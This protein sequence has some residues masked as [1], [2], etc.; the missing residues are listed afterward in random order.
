MKNFLSK[1]AFWVLQILGWGCLGIFVILANDIT[2]SNAARIIT[3]VGF[4]FVSIGVTSITR[5]FFRR[6]ID[7]QDFKAIEFFKIV[8]IIVGTTLVFP[9]VSYWFGYLIGKLMKFLFDDATDLFRK[10]EGEYDWRD[11]KQYIGYLIIVTGWTVFYFV[12]KVLRQV[13][14]QRVNRLELKKK[15]RQAQLNTLKGHINPQFMFNTLNNIKGLMLEDVPLSRAMLT[16]LS[17]MLRYS[18]TKNS[19]NTVLIAEE[20]EMVE[21]YVALTQIQHQDRFQIKYDIPKETLRLEIPP[22]LMHNL[23]EHAAKNGI[24]LRRTGGEIL[25]QIVRD[26]NCVHIYVSH[27]GANSGRKEST[28]LKKTLE[29]RLRLMYGEEALFLEEMN[30]KATKY[31]LTVPLEAIKANTD[32]TLV[33]QV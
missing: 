10:P 32:S 20:L 22:M 11:I 3:L 25:L 24:L 5:L 9:H 14:K 31:T 28:Q 12:V 26:K 4:M 27:T 23:V 18:L 29:H 17:E 1:N 6:F 7:L 30:E 19:V 2:R 8:L 16:R 21:N 33:K 15:V 13:N